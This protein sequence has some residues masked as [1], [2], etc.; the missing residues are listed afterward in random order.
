MSREREELADRGIP[1]MPRNEMDA[2]LEHQQLAPL[3]DRQ[4]ADDMRL[5]WANV[6]AAFVDSPGQAVQRADQ[7]VE[8]VLKD[9][10][11]GF[12]R[13]RSEIES[14]AMGSD[15]QPASTESMRV[16]LRRYRSF[17]ERLLSL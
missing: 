4:R 13:Q 9:L 6:Q 8:Q 1:G 11:D 17:F 7:L 15:D 3:F 5:E 16:A 12:S 2:G 14:Q 10:A